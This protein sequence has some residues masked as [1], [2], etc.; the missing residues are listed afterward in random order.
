MSDES[1]ETSVRGKIF[2]DIDL[3]LEFNGYARNDGIA[4][5]PTRIMTTNNRHARKN[6]SSII[7]L[8]A[9]QFVN[10]LSCSFVYRPLP[11]KSIKSPTGLGPQNSY[12]TVVS[13]P[14]AQFA[15][16]EVL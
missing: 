11:G 12:T 5:Y 14:S 6:S 10:N 8:A 2:D 15:A 1:E 16:R 7:L 13:L 3:P 9:A 4:A